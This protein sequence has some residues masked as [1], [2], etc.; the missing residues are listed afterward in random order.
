MIY[1]SR[2]S[3]NSQSYQVSIQ[4]WA[5][6]C[7]PAKCHLNSVSLAVQT[8][9]YLRSWISLIQI[10]LSSLFLSEIIT[11]LERTQTQKPTQWE[12]WRK[13]SKD[14]R[15]LR[16]ALSKINFLRPTFSGI[17]I[18]SPLMNKKKCQSCRVGPPLTI[19]S[20]STHEGTILMC[21]RYLNY[22][23]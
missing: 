9:W 12:G 15:P 5:V 20:G 23:I 17:W 14:F 3:E 18:L 10:N 13:N 7:P 1:W 2:T 8:F 11:K 6:I 21:L 19:V 4:C 16:Y 22:S